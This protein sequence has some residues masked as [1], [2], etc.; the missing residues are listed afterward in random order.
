MSGTPTVS[1]NGLQAEIY[2]WIC[3]LLIKI[4]LVFS[5]YYLATSAKSFAS[6]TV[7]WF[8]PWQKVLV[9]T[10][11]FAFLWEAA[12][13]SQV[14]NFWC[15]SESLLILWKPFDIT[16]VFWYYQMILLKLF[17]LRNSG[18]K[19]VCNKMLRQ[20]QNFSV[21][22]VGTTCFTNIIFLTYI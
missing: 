6:C 3:S 17:S 2:I 8:L 15:F 9:L 11:D 1:S 12:E 18:A 22:Q 4:I 19:Y 14:N 10:N 20:I 21:Y 7:T 16:K 5:R 13:N